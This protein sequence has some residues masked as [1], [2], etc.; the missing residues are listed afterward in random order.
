MCSPYAEKATRREQNL[1]R[2]RKDCREDCSP[3]RLALICPRSLK[4]R[5]SLVAPF[6][7]CAQQRAREE[8]NERTEKGRKKGARE[9]AGRRRR[10]RDEAKRG[11]EVVVLVCWSSKL[12]CPLIVSLL[13]RNS[14]TDG[15]MERIAWTPLTR[16]TDVEH[17]APSNLASKSVVRP[18]RC[19][20]GPLMLVPWHARQPGGFRVSSRQIPAE[21]EK[22]RRKIING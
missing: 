3:D 9:R 19:G 7:S 13:H 18:G 2:I 21:A 14:L 15:S 12:H 4:T 8:R 1:S 20:P 17:H 6:D 5:R 10:K 11:E 22:Q 16:S